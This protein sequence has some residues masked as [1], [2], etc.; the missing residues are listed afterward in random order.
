MEVLDWWAFTDR[1]AEVC[2]Y[3]LTCVQR[4]LA[5]PEQTEYRVAQQVELGRLLVGG[6]DGVPAPPPQGGDPDDVARSAARLGELSECFMDAPAGRQQP[7][8]LRRF[9]ASDLFVELAQRLA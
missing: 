7:T 5:G 8:G 4:R 9:A 6:V 2:G 3:V 1:G